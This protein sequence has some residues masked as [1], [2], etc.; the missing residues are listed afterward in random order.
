MNKTKYYRTRPICIYAIIVGKAPLQNVVFGALTPL[1]SH[2]IILKYN[3]T[4]IYF[5]K[6]KMNL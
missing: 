3:I 5:I 2:N 4:F 6:F 1:K